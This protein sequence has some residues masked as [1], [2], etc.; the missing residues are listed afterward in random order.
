[1]PYYLLLVKDF[2]MYEDPQTNEE[3]FEVQAPTAAD[4]I[5]IG[6]VR[7]NFPLEEN[8]NGIA[9][10]GGLHTRKLVDVKVIS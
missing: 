8:R 9:R 3:A 4:A 7:H 2:Q 10:R 5:T 1:M 6:Q